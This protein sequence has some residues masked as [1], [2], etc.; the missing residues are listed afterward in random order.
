MM[1]CGVLLALLALAAAPRTGTSSAIGHANGPYHIDS[2]K[3]AIMASNSNTKISL[4]GTRLLLDH[5]RSAAQGMCV[6][7]FVNKANNPSSSV[8]SPLSITNGVATCTFTVAD[9]K[10]ILDALSADLTAGKKQQMYLNIVVSN[11]DAN[12]DWLPLNLYNPELSVV[13]AVA[14]AA[15]LF[16]RGPVDGATELVFTGTSFV[17]SA[18]AT[19]LTQYNEVWTPHAATFVSSTMYRCTI[20][21]AASSLAQDTALRLKLSMSSD[22]VEAYTDGG[23]L[24]YVYTAAAPTVETVSA[25]QGG[26]V[27]EVTWNG[28]IAERAVCETALVLDVRAL[29][30]ANDCWYSAPAA[31]ISANTWLGQQS[32]S[33]KIA[34][35]VFF[36]GVGGWGA[37]G[38]Y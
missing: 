11:N 8:T 26:T 12:V 28:P 23:T 3:P 20:G 4:N 9:K 21:K 18:D 17:E 13:T 1:N 16:A 6:C 5:C 24:R 36:W 25:M 37:G 38:G 2:F 22:P 7:K 14:D 32:R 27:V 35:Y 31:S 30:Q 33:A 29:S 34:M 10:I 19:C 15:A